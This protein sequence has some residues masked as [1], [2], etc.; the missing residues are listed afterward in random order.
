MIIDYFMTVREG[1]LT[2]HTT[3]KLIDRITFEMDNMNTPIS[4]FLELFKTF[5][6]CDRQILT[7]KL[8][9]YG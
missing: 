5:D 3:L 2:E 6:T 1:H 7:E 8:E 9:Y 4:T